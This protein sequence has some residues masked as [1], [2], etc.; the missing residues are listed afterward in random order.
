MK[1]SRFVPLVLSFILVFSAQAQYQKWID[2][3]E[4]EYEKGNYSG[5]RNKIEGMLKTLDKKLG[6]KNSYKAIAL[7]KEAKIKVGLGELV[8][9]M[10]P[11]EKGIAMSEEVNG[12]QSTEHGFIMLEATDVLISYGHFRLAATYVAQAI[13][14]FQSSDSYMEDLKA[15]IEVQ[16]AQILAGK[17]FY[18][19][20][21]KVVNAQSS[22]FLKRALSEEGA[23]QDIEERKEEYAEMMIVKANSFRKMGNYLSADSAFI[24]NLAWVKEHLKKSHLL[25]AKNAFLNA[26]LLE[27][28]GLAVEA[29]SKL[30]EEAYEA[31]VRKYDLSHNTVMTLQARLMRAYYQNNQTARL[32]IAREDFKKSLREFGDNSIFN[33][34]KTKMSI[35]Y[36]V[37][38][39]DIEEL[40]NKLN[41]MLVNPVVP[42]FHQ[43]RITLIE[44][45]KK[46][47]LYDGKPKNTEAYDTEILKIKAELL[48]TDAPEYHLTK[49]KLANYYV[50]FS[51]KFDE[52]EKIY[53]ESFHQMVYPEITQGH[54]D[55]LDI[56]NH[57][58]KF[59]QEIDDYKK[60][61]ELLDEAL[62]AARV[63]Y[64]N[65]DIEYGHELEK[66]AN[67]QVSMGEYKKAEAN[68]EE[69][70]E[71]LEDSDLDLALTYLSEVMVTKAKLRAI[72]GEYDESED[73]IYE[74]D[75]LRED[76]ALTTDVPSIHADEDLGGL[77]INVGRYRDAQKLLEKA[78]K[79]KVRQYG[80]DSRHL[81]YS[82]VQNAKLNLIRGDYTEAEHQARKA[83]TLST[84][85]FSEK[86]SKT[87]PSMLTLA[88]IYTL[89]GDYEKAELLLDKAIEIQKN[90][91]GDQHIDVG[92]SISKL[93][94]V[95]FYQDK[96]L[97]EIEERF[98]IAEQIIGKGLGSNNP[99]YAEILKNMAIANIASGKYRFAFTYL[100]QAETIWKSKIGKR[101]NVNAAN[102]L[103]LKGD[104]YYKQ[105]KYKEAEDFYE[106]AQKQYVRIFNE[107]HPEFVKVQS[108]LSKTY[109]MQA[110]YKEA[111]DEIEAVL[112]NYKT[113]IKK[114]FPA[115]SEREKAK[116]W[117]T[118]KSDY[119]FYNSL[120]ISRNRSVKYI[121]E[122]YNNALLTKALLLNSSIKVRQRI[123]NSEDE[124]LVRLYTQWIEDKELLTAALSMSTE[125]L[126]SNGIDPQSLGGEVELLEKEISLKS[127][128]FSQSTDAKVIRW[129]EVKS[130]LGGNEVAMEMVRFRYFDHTFT[131]S[132]MYALLY[133]A[134]D[135]KEPKMILL[136]D[137][138]ELEKRYMKVYRNSIKYKLNDR[139]S[140]LKFWKPIEDEIGAVSSLYLSPDG[141]Y[142]QINL[143]AIKRPDE[144]YVL[145][146]SNIK[147]VS[148]TKALYLNTLHTRPLSEKEYAMMFG[149]PTFYVSTEPG[150]PTLTSGL[151]RATATNVSPL[152]GTKVEIEELNDLLDRK[153]W[154]TD[155]FME[156]NATESQIKKVSNP[157]I[158]HVATHGFFQNESKATKSLEYNASAAY[159]NPLLK[160]GLLMSG[161]GDILNQTQF[162]YNLDDGIL[163]AYEAMNLNLDKTDIVALSACE[164][165]L[166]E[167]EAGEG[168]Y[169]LQRAFLVAGART[170]IMSLFKVNDQ[171][172][173][174]LMLKFYRKWIE[175]GKKRQAFVEAKKEI[176]NEYGD[177]IYWGPFV[178]IGLD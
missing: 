115:L 153:G 29:R 43:E 174:Q 8:A 2:K 96:P 147:L 18:K 28:N 24:A 7:I 100:N 12:A 107:N 20:A 132:V 55:Y 105:K 142:N 165:G 163:T 155:Q 47:A 23:K 98:Q 92:K 120:I 61:S 37:A 17:G 114:Y 63:K 89:I 82:Y 91:F 71:I 90:T 73:L 164:T 77:Y 141:V 159:D 97:T 74:S 126:A 94:L 101:N 127:E 168:V 177:P 52:A 109:Y 121:G 42:A 148:N 136:K 54:I 68:I 53:Q 10:D 25:W 3:V 151:T 21:V 118:I 139:Y 14:A 173:Q 4:E 49:V 72:E 11:L 39:Q 6:P 130:V 162:N 93:A 60:A 70:I 16:K 135:Y 36:D 57:L 41:E 138:E 80:K 117:N 111:Q 69:A 154:E 50:D 46:I 102:A 31:A 169:G 119:E 79:D 112:G 158:F 38:D 128:L 34:A 167:I 26:R 134:G 113:F 170:I 56:I 48:G 160:T 13:S 15:K 59:Y 140:Y 161:A 145:D 75:E 76:G 66:I 178:M 143:E 83:N 99:T 137:G 156:M 44:M 32:N 150:T 67:L 84:S 110:R 125:D 35:A 176:R 40:E 86:S 33:L 62:L 152:P 81:V 146:N 106:S 51:D 123:L 116:F 108:K 124:E 78:L 122:L 5:A 58:A 87:V 27:E 45:A 65:K 95:Y 131:D 149:N 64:D 85:I 19:E 22:Y 172:T 103:A 133:V 1:L 30:Y 9:V 157:R 171:V 175:T 144:K 88:D 129:E 104:I 166:G